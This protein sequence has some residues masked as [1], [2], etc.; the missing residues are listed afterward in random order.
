MVWHHMQRI[1]NIDVVTCISATCMHGMRMHT[2]MH[3][4]C[5]TH[6]SHRM[7]FA[8]IGVV[9]YATHRCMRFCR[10]DKR[11]MHMC[12]ASPVSSITQ[13][14]T[15]HTLDIKTGHSCQRMLVDISMS[16]FAAIHHRTA[17]CACCNLAH[18]SSHTHAISCH[19]RHAS[20]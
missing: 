10:V 19:P 11:A 20:V 5:N 3:T 2:I 18:C 16:I 14:H 9:G 6:V 4:A 7:R 13:S 15:H 12:I 1:L 8:I 17:A